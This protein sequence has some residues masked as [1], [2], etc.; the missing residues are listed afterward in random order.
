MK[1]YIV[2]KVIPGN[3]QTSDIWPEITFLN[4]DNFIWS[5]NDYQ[6]F[7]QAG[8]FYTDTHLHVFFKSYED[9][10]SVKHFKMN[11]DVYKDSC[12]EF[13]INPKPGEQENYMNFE[14]N[15]A[16]TLLL[17]SGRT[18]HNRIRYIFD[19]FRELF[20][21]KTSVTKENIKNYD[22]KFWTLEYAIPFT[23]FEKYFGSINIK[24]G[25]TMKGN[26]YKCGDST[27]HPHYGCWNLITDPVPD[28]HLSSFFGSI[29]F[30]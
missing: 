19:D 20:S 6:P 21:I 27:T 9:K 13:F 5:S 4:I 15:A 26:F 1:T 7:T 22:C 16:G 8:L 10:I 24:P 23:F 3:R 18:R 2:K 12:C 30:E 17:G 29:V 28:F 25:Y 14:I 11:E